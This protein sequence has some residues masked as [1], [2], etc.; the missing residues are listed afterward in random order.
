[1][2]STEKRIFEKRNL[3]DSRH[4]DF[5]RFQKP[6][7]EAPQK[8]RIFKNDDPLRSAPQIFLVFKNYRFLLARSAKK[9]EAHHLRS[10]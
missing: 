3:P 7:D 6:N 10:L 5:R 9:K 8:F 4:A 1:V 2:R